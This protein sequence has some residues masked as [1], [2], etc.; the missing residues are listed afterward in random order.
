MWDGSY[1]ASGESIILLSF[2][3]LR[4]RMFSV[5]EPSPGLYTDKLYTHLH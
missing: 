3:Q 2:Q 4:A 1:P 5:Q